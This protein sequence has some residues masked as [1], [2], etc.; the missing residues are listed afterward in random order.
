MICPTWF[1]TSFLRERKVLC[2]CLMLSMSWSNLFVPIVHPI[3]LSNK[4]FKFYV[5]AGVCC[6]SDW[7]RL[8]LFCCYQ[9]LCV[10]SQQSWLGGFLFHKFYSPDWPTWRQPERVAQS[11]CSMRCLRPEPRKWPLTSPAAS[12]VGFL[13]TKRVYLSRYQSCVTELSGKWLG[14]L[15]QES[16]ISFKCNGVDGFGQIQPILYFSLLYKQWP[17][18]ILTNF[19]MWYPKENKARLFPVTLY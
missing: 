6:R 5:Y 16:N 19:V 9:P 3:P 10:V 13:G 17:G 2:N 14:K 4:L 8:C 7:P 15:V 1:N 18:T 11:W 12:M